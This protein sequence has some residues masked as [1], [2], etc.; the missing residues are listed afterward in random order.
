MFIVNN[1]QYLDIQK[2]VS[3]QEKNMV[4]NCQKTLSHLFGLK[5]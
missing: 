3:D 5:T 1:N 2:D 4:G